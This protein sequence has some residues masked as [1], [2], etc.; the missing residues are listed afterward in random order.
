MGK[1]KWGLLNGS[2]CKLWC[3]DG[4]ELIM[5]TAVKDCVFINDQKE[6]WRTHAWLSKQFAAVKDCVFMNNQKERWRTHAWLS[7]QFAA[8]KDYVFINDQK[9]RSRTHAWL[10]KQFARSLQ[11]LWGTGFRGIFDVAF[12]G[13]L[14]VPW[15]FRAGR[16]RAWATS[17]HSES[18]RAPRMS[19]SILYSLFSVVFLCPSVCVAPKLRSLHFTHPV[20]IASRYFQ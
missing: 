10:S 15:V 8:V 14:G 3:N 19:L 18:L 5:L 7:K 1:K 6:R 4:F 16:P 2:K 12:S 9:E 13:G 17:P 20:Y 11:L